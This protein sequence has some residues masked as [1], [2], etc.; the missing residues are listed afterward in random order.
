M[1]ALTNERRLQER[2]GDLEDGR[3]VF[4]LVQIGYGRGDMNAGGDT[5]SQTHAQM[6]R[7]A[8]IKGF[9]HIGDFDYFGDAGASDIGLQDIGGLLRQPG[10]ELI[11]R[12]FR[13]ADC[14]RDGNRPCQ[15]GM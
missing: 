9:R 7:H 15:L 13:L 11:A 2:I 4:E 6:R 12:A 3:L 10:T 8:D 5:S 14:D 1:S